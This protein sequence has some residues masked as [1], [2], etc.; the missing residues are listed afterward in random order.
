VVRVVVDRLAIANREALQ[1]ALRA[2][3]NG[4]CL[5][6]AAFGRP[7]AGIAK[8]LEDRDYDIAMFRWPA[9]W[10]MATGFQPDG[11]YNRHERAHPVLAFRREEPELLGRTAGANEY[12]PFDPLL[13]TRLQQC[14]DGDSAGCAALVLDPEVLIPWTSLLWIY[15]SVPGISTMD[16]GYES[17]EGLSGL[18]SQGMEIFGS[19]LAALVTSEGKER[20]EEFWKSSATPQVAFRE[21]FGVGLGEWIHEQLPFYSRRGSATSIMSPAVTLCFT[22][23]AFAISIAAGRRRQLT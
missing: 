20:F 5:F 3:P 6:Y 1:L 15:E 11:R 16:T 22:L 2:S 13:L 4:V 18:S 7:G 9:R 17:Y 8:W 21:T 23:F 19:F 14:S 10:R 12:F